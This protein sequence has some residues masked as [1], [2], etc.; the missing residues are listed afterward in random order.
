MN[1]KK[2]AEIKFTNPNKEKPEIKI[3]NYEV[4][5]NENWISKCELVKKTVPNEIKD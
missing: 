5:V 2:I 4:K 1:F 3:M